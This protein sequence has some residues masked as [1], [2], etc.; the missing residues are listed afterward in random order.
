MEKKQLKTTEYLR[1]DFTVPEQRENARTLA[2]K[3]QALDEIDARRKRLMADLKAEEE[4]ALAEVQKLARWVHDE[5]DYRMID[6][7]CLL[8]T[9]R[10]G[11]K[12]LV[13]LDTG[14]VLKEVAM[15]S[16][17][18]QEN[19]PFEESHEEPAPEAA[20]AKRPRICGKCGQPG[21]NARTCKGAG[22]AAQ[23]A[24]PIL[25]GVR[26]VEELPDAFVSQDKVL[27]CKGAYWSPNTDYTAWN[28]VSEE[29]A[30]K[31]LELNP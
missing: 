11:L 29:A 25:P 27:H 6:C 10:N 7:E 30:R 19:L 17:E 4:A 23:V 20:P 28:M 16:T 31:A 9:P 12:R 13:R 5:Y 21:H 1:Y 8:N 22:P 3:T 18:L 26:E 2:R 24:L 15:V 14:E